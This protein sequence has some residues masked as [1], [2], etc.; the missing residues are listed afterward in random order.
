MEMPQPPCR[1]SRPSSL[2][3]WSLEPDPTEGGGLCSASYVLPRPEMTEPQSVSHPHL[4]PTPPPYTSGK[5][6]V[7]GPRRQLWE[8]TGVTSYARWVCESVHQDTELQLGMTPRPMS[9]HV[10]GVHAGACKHHPECRGSSGCVHTCSLGSPAAIRPQGRSGHLPSFSCLWL[11]GGGLGFSRSRQGLHSP[12][13][14]HP[15][16][17]QAL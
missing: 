10:G 7:S 12:S 16:C 6:G 9:V 15:R 11:V 13:S 1:A 2:L 3:F 17:L 14:L 4:P 5:A 8:A